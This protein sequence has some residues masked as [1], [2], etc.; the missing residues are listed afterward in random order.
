MANIIVKISN[1]LKAIEHYIKNL[2]E[3]LDQ[4]YKENKLGRSNPIVIYPGTASIK[5]ACDYTVNYA[6]A[7]ISDEYLE[8]TL[9]PKFSGDIIIK[10]FQILSPKTVKTII[11]FCNKKTINLYFIG[12]AAHEWT[13]AP[14]EALHYL[15]TEDY[16]ISNIEEHSVKEAIGD[17]VKLASNFPT[18]KKRWSGRKTP[19]QIL[20]EV[21]GKR[22]RTK[23]A[24]KY[25]NK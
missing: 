12:E 7:D 9:G 14:S 4:E 13:S 25:K 18:R 1:N 24:I 6:N 20:D 11:K 19:E 22:R 8:K 15:R 10:N 2:L 3:T 5:N 16:E 21:N 23:S 17:N